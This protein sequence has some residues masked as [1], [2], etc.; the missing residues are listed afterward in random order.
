MLSWWLEQFDPS[1]GLTFKIKTL[2]TDNL[3]KTITNPGSSK[4]R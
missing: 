2:S 1:L 4:M 3:V